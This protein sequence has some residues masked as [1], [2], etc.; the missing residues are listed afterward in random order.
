MTEQEFTRLFSLYRGCIYRICLCNMRN[1]ADADDIT[2]DTFLKLYTKAPAF[3]SDEQAKAWLIRVAV[4]GCR[5]IM[6][7]L[8]FRLSEPIDEGL[9]L[10]RE[11]REEGRLL[12]V[13]MELK[14]KLR[15]VM[16]MYYYEEYSV[17]EIAGLLKLKE[18]AVT[19]RLMRGRE[20]LKQLIEREGL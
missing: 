13:V 14:P 17:K 9:E 1:A 7:S 12:S 15:T 19:S 8:R 20:Q 4:N 10:P 6:K 11:K 16:Y 2:Q 3:R 18:T 5:D